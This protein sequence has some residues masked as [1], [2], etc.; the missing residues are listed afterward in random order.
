MAG[1]ARRLG[2]ARRYR[3]GGRD[4]ERRHRDRNLPG[5]P[6]RKDPGRSSQ[7]GAGRDA[8]G[9]DSNRGRSKA[10]RRRGR[11]ASASAATGCAA[12]AAPVAPP[13]RRRC[14][15]AAAAR[16]A[17]AAARAHRPQRASLPKSAASIFQRSPAAARAGRSP[18]PTSSAVS[19]RPAPLRRKRSGRRGSISTPCERPSPP[20][21]RDRSGKSRITISSIRSTSR[22]AS[23]G[24]RRKMR[25]C[26]PIAALL[27]GRTC[28]QGSR[29]GRAPLSRFQRVLSRQ[30]V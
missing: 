15:H 16:V 26:R 20:R 24:W 11:S 19:A 7:Q 14:P 8:A 3:R 30:Q 25:R 28:A 10:R 17:G 2:Q 18:M 1:Q 27:I 9:A 4:A 21:W 13:R 6:D 12:S 5:R 23:N 29:L 22:L